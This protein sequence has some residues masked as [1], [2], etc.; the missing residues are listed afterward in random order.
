MVSETTPLRAWAVA[1]V[2]EDRDGE[3]LDVL[4]TLA[5][6]WGEVEAKAS[7]GRPDAQLSVLEL[8][9]G[10]LDLALGSTRAWL[11]EQE[12]TA[13]VALGEGAEG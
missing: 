1:T 11:A 7:A 12:A 6:S 5:D 13:A 2:W 4:V 3:H 9:V 8:P 10:W